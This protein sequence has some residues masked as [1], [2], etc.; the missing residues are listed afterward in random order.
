[1]AQG[2]CPEVPDRRQRG[3]KKGAEQHPAPRA[4]QHQKGPQLPRGT[5]QEEEKGGGSGTEDKDE[6]RRGGEPRTAAQGPEQVIDQGS[7]GPQQNGPE[8]AA[9]RRHPSR[10]LQKPPETGASS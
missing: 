10:R 1:M 4:A 8:K 3:R 2:V 7:G 9:K 6:V 5:A